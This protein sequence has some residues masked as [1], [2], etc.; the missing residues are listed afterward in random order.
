MNKIKPTSR[1]I[2]SKLANY[3]DNKKKKTLKSSKTKRL[4]LE[5]KTHKAS[6]QISEQILGKPEASD[7]TYSKC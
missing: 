4:H 1:H 2:V 3:S 5:G 6:Y 7:I